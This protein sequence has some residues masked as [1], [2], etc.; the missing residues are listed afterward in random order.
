MLGL[1]L[2]RGIRE[3]GLDARS[4]GLLEGRGWLEE[5]EGRLRLTPAGRHFHSEAAAELI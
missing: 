5:A 1:R 2:D 3:D 4:V